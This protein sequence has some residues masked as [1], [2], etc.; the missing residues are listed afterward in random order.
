MKKY[1]LFK[2]NLGK[3]KKQQTE[4]T[5]QVLSK[6]LRQKGMNKKIEIIQNENISS[7]FILGILKGKI[8]LPNIKFSE[9]EFEYIISHEINHF[10]SKDSLKKV[11]IQ[12]IKHLFWWNPLVHLF[13]NN[14][15]QILE[16]QCDLNTTFNFSKEDKIKYL[17]SITKIIRKCIKTNIESVKYVTAPSFVQIEEL[18]S[19]KQRFR[20]VLNYRPKRDIF[21]IFNILLYVSALF[22]FISSY[23]IIIQPDYKPNQDG[24]Y[25]KKDENNSFILENLEGSYDIYIDSMFKYSIKNL[26]D[27]NKKLSDLPIIKEGV[28]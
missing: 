19:L 14:F 2:I 26:E 3:L 8:Y 17:E 28:D 7:P 1:I 27:L 10:L 24:I 18:D 13:A 25:K 11:L 15:N 12:S 22:L 20:I 21:K 6:I 4:K 16:I 5:G 9:E 23:F